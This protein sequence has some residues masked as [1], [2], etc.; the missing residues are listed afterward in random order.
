M[1]CL[2]AQYISNYNSLRNKLENCY[3]EAHLVIILSNLGAVQERNL[4][5]P[6]KFILPSKVYV[7]AHTCLLS[8]QYIAHAIDS[9]GT[10]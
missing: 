4:S 10:P 7:E 5:K 1:C 9:E 3:N 6:I 8:T 2:N